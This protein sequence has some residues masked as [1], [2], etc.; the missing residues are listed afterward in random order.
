MLTQILYGM[1][2][3]YDAQLWEAGTWLTLFQYL[4]A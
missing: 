3:E 2:L 1:L 4:L